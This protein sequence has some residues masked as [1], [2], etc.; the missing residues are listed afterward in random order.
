MS[1]ISKQPPAVDRQPRIVGGRGRDPEPVSRLLQAAAR[2]YAVGGLWGGEGHRRDPP[3]RQPDHADALH[4][5]GLVAWRRGDRQQGLEET[6]KAIASHPT[7][8]QP[9]N[10]LSVMLK[11]LGDLDGAEAAFRKAIDL[12][13]N[14]PDA[15]TNLGNILCETGR[16]EAAEA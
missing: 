3:Q 8:P 9:Y 15:L 2:Q 1:D 11:E 6:R 12:M 5:L 7:K 14:Y 10:S 4:I 16:L 13:P